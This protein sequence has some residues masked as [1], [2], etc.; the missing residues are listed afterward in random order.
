MV[1]RASEL[2]ALEAAICS[3]TVQRKEEGGLPT[4]APAVGA[5][6]D[7]KMNKMKKTTIGTTI[8]GTTLRCRTR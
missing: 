1:L 2:E 3:R 5:E 6:R 4:R 7:S 8:G